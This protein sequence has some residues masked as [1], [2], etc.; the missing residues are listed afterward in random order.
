MSESFLIFASVRRRRWRFLQ[1]TKGLFVY[2]TFNKSL[3]S[4]FSCSLLVVKVNAQGKQKHLSRNYCISD[5]WEQ[6]WAV[7]PAN[8]TPFSQSSSHH[9]LAPWSI[10]FNYKSYMKVCVVLMSIIHICYISYTHTHSD[11]M[12]W[13]SRGDACQSGGHSV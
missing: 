5:V 3:A 4:S 9:Y 10:L 12:M 11:V 13:Y 2:F 6:R 7:P 1:S 8:P